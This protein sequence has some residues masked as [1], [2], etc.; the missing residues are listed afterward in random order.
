M[1]LQSS[2]A[3]SF[4]NLQT[5]FG[6]SHPI[7]MGEYSAFRVSG[8]GNTISMNQF[9]GAAGTLD[10]QTV[11]VGSTVLFGATWS[12]YTSTFPTFGSISDGTSNIYSGATIEQIY[13]IGTN[14][15]L[16]FTVD[17]THANSGWTTMTIGSSSYTRTSAI[18][19]QSSGNTYWYWNIGSAEPFGTSGTK[20][21][22]WT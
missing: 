2:G 10:T 17:G 14:N 21:V 20:T 12:G 6:G 1:A 15:R 19:S 7:T 13:K 18:H 8:S 3:I 16:Y 5:E 4:A 9:Y 22:D 11:T